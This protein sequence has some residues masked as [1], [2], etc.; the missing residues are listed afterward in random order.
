MSAGEAADV[1]EAGWVE[2]ATSKHHDHVVAHVVGAT[3]MGYF[4]ADDALHLL[5]D[6]GFF[7]IIYADGEMGLV[8]ESTTV[9]E[10]NVSDEM[11]ASIREETNALRRADAGA[12]GLSILS[13]APAGC[14]IEEVRFYCRGA[15]RRLLIRGEA[16]SL[17]VE[18]SVET[19]EIAISEL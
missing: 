1:T 16:A 15:W 4:I 8:A 2:A 9:A 11:R 3:V 10:L 18:G 12:Q 6:I 19:G 5:L 17:S 14:L 13:V 7:W